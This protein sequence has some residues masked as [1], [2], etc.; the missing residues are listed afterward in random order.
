MPRFITAYFSLVYCCDPDNS[1][2]RAPGGG[3]GARGGRG[4]GRGGQ[5]LICLSGSVFNST[6][7]CLLHS[8]CSPS[9]PPLSVSPS[10]FL[11]L[12]SS[13]IV[14]SLSHFLSL[15]HALAMSSFVLL[16]AKDKHTFE[17][18]QRHDGGSGGRGSGAS[19][20]EGGGGGRNGGGG[21]GGRD[22]FDDDFEEDADLFASVDLDVR[23]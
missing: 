11:S 12:S 18:Q 2:E 9:S 6:W 22:E 19:R 23:G 20:G 5:G 14:L 10:L 13:F 17:R 4:G 16:V 1:L 15:D 8:A 7:L 3:G 21:G